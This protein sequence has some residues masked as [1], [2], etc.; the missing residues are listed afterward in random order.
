M[1]NSVRNTLWEFSYSEWNKYFLR[2]FMRQL[3][4]SKRAALHDL[5]PFFPSII[6]YMSFYSR[7]W[8]WVNKYS[9][10][11]KMIHKIRFQNPHNFTNPIKFKS[12]PFFYLY[13]SVVWNQKYGF[14]HRDTQT[15]TNS[16]T[17]HTHT[18]TCTHQSNHQ[19][20]KT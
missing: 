17:H 8:K 9:L 14:L 6:V 10:E 7:I 13:K 16:R 19:P 11:V 2:L 1:L 20:S 12:L 4:S 18:R 3:G 15:H 5:L